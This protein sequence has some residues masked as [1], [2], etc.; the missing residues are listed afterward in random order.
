MNNT[1]QAELETLKEIIVNTVPV[2]Q[3]YLLYELDAIRSIRAAVYPVKKNQW[4]YW[5]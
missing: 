4:I 3:I 1:I 5:G 2:E